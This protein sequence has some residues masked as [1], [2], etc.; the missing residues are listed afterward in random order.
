MDDERSPLERSGRI[1][2]REAR[3]HVLA[4]LG[5]AIAARDPILRMT[6]VKCEL[7]QAVS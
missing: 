6:D 7:Q 2:K 4:G 5:T 1:S 3:M